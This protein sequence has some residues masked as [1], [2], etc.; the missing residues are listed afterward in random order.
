MT[1][2]ARAARA[3]ADVVRRRIGDHVPAAAIV[4][5]SGL[6]ALADEI[7]AV[8]TIPYADVPGFPD[9]TVAGHA[10][11]LIAGTLTGRFVLALS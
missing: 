6:G 5:G 9:A 3:A 4:L 1:F 7:A 10:G 11:A 8:A 2:G